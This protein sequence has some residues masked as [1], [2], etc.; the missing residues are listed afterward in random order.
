MTRTRIASPVPTVAFV[1]HHGSAKSVIAAAQFRN[2]VAALGYLPDVTALGT[3][4]DAAFPPYVL[5]GMRKDGLTPNASAPRRATAAALRHAH[6][7]VTFGPE[8]AHL[9]PHHCRLRVWPDVPPVSGG[10]GPASMEIYRR[11]ALL[12]EELVCAEGTEAG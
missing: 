6:L 3:E 8:V 10:Y 4:P 12:V 5:E 7:V 9:L 1:C 2:L 11:V